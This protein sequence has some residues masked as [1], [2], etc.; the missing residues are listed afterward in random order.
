VLLAL[1]DPEG[2]L[3]GVLVAS[4]ALAA[5]LPIL[6]G[7]N[8]EAAIRAIWRQM[9]GTP[10]SKED[11]ARV[12]AD[13]D[14][15]LLLE[16]ERLE[17][18]RAAAL[19]AYRAQPAR[20]ATHADASYPE[21]PEACEEFLRAREE[22]AAGAPVPARVGAVLAPH[23]DLRGGGPCHGAAAR[24][25]RAC[26]ASTFVVLGTAHA[27]LRR[28]FALT[29]S[30]FA[31]PVGTV[32]TDRDLVE[33]LAKRGGGRLLDDELA[34]RG[35]HSV[36]FQA[37]WLA[38][39]RHGGPAPRIVPVLVGSLHD[40]IRDGASPMSDPEF[41]DFVEALCE[42]GRERGGD[43]AFVASVDLAH[44]GPRYGHDRAVDDAWLA[45]VMAADRALLS[46]ALSGDAD[47]WLR[48]LHE[49]GDR[50]NVCGAAPTYAF[51]Q[52]IRAQGLGAT[53]GGAPGT[54]L[55]HDEWEIDPATKSHVSFAAVA[56]ASAESGPPR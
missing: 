1:R 10:M 13:L 32:A 52:A 23:I 25:L 50:R 46:H 9:T 5:L 26:P 49:E 40:R 6:D 12:L 33:R 38:H 24:A 20:A 48:A 53:G 8:D 2:L 21:E 42:V 27:P 47:G 56:Y 31:T 17:A 7:T 41:A 54:L 16:G 45:E 22:A 55:R 3:D 34:H 15:R 4:P 11:L 51:L 39:V 36:E 44:V 28:R 43:V 18:A 35:E 30:D 29:T 19:A 37:V 14:E